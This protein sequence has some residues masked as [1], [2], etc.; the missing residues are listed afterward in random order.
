MSILGA[1]YAAHANEKREEWLAQREKEVAELEKKLD[2]TEKVLAYYQAG[3][4]Q[5]IEELESTIKK[6]KGI[7][8]DPCKCPCCGKEDCEWHMGLHTNE[9]FLEAEVERLTRARIGDAEIIGRWQCQAEKAEARLT[10]AN[11]AV[12]AIK[13]ADIKAMAYLYDEYKKNGK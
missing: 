5:K 4:I 6:L 3:K 7:H 8:L 10:A 2:D 9:A 1:I 13:N 12:S 11:R